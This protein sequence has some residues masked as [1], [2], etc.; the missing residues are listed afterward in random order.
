MTSVK[1]QPFVIIPLPSGYFDIKCFVN[2]QSFLI[3]INFMMFTARG[4]GS[5]FKIHFEIVFLPVTNNI[6]QKVPI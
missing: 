5:L 6:I 4:H 3:V 1:S 2:L